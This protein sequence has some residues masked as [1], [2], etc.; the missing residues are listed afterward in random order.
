MD[1]FYAVT[2][3]TSS[4]W[5]QLHSRVRKQFD[6]GCFSSADDGRELRMLQPQTATSEC[7]A[8]VTRC[9]RNPEDRNFQVTLSYISFILEDFEQIIHAFF[10]SFCIHEMDIKMV[11]V[12]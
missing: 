6:K 1:L 8:N 9:S 4:P 3:H 12:T 2:A 10:L 7:D 11:C 5:R